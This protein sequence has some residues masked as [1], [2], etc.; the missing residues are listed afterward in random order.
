LFKSALEGFSNF[1][2]RE[3]LG[4][5]SPNQ[6]EITY[7]NQ[8]VV[9]EGWERFGQIGEVLTICTPHHSDDFLQEPETLSFQAAYVIP[10][11]SGEPLG[12]LYISAQ[13]AFRGG[14][15]KPI[16]VVQVTA[17]GRP[18]GGGLSG[19]ARF[20]ETGHEWALRGFLSATSRHMHEVWKIRHA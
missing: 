17:R 11:S 15:N 6:C 12:R 19:A 20:L 2:E 4:S 1:L 16:L 14:D 9:G 7:V 10:A 8:I 3:R 5:V 13:P 18:D